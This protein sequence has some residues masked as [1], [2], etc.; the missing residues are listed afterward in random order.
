MN[1]RSQ[2]FGGVP[3]LVKEKRIY[4][5]FS[6]RFPVKFKDARQ[7]FGTN[8]F[9]RNVSAGGA[10]ITTKERIFLNDSVTLEVELLDGKGPMMIRGEVAW[11]KGL[12][13]ELWDVGL[14]FYDVILMD[15]WRLY[16]SAENVSH[17]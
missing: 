12:E 1:E 2:N 9:L 10:K 17:A 6:S 11:T 7:D 4:D 13:P 3:D 16:K 5:R 14:R 15:L 8:V